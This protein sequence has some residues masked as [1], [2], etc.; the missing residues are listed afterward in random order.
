MKIIQASERTRERLRELKELMEGRSESPETR[1]DMVQL[2]ARTGRHP[3]P[4]LKAQRAGAERAGPLA[5]V[6]ISGDQRFENWKLR[7]ALRRPY[8]LRS[9]VRLSRVRNPSS[10]SA[11]RN[12]G[13]K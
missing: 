7:R 9:T 11:G 1:S 2:A 10:F 3:L 12:S 5:K 13:S 8:F 6:P 4:C